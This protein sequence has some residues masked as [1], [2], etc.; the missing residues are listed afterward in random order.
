MTCGATC[1]GGGIAGKFISIVATSQY[2]S[3]FGASGVIPSQTFTT[4]A[5]VETN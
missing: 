4:S 2:S 1:S 5:V 3:L